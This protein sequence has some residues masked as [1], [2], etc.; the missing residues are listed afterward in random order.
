[1]FEGEGAADSD[2]V[3]TSAVSDTAAVELAVFPY[4]VLSFMVRWT[5]A[6]E[7]AL[8]W[9]VLRFQRLWSLAR[10]EMLPNFWCK[11]CQV[12]GGYT[13]GGNCLEV[14]GHVVFSST[15]ALFVVPQFILVPLCFERRK[16]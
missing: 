1:M 16:L 2:N 13:R 11:R 12:R 15:H 7:L 4:F 8:R 14:Q 9:K 5:L 10:E 6:V 3:L